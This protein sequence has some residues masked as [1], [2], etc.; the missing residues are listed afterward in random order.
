MKNIKRNSCLYNNKIIGIENF[1]YLSDSG[2][3]IKVDTGKIEEFRRLGSEDKLFCPCGCGARLCIV[4][5]EIQ[6]KHFRLKKNQLKIDE[7]CNWSEET[8]ESISSK[9]ILKIWLEQNNCIGLRRDILTSEIGHTDKKY[10]ITYYEPHRQIGVSY[11]RD[12]YNINEDKLNTISSILK[13]VFFITSIHNINNLW[14]YPEQ[15]IKIQKE[16][17]YTILLENNDNMNYLEAKLL[18]IY[19]YKDEYEEWTK[20]TIAYDYIQKYT[21]EDDE[22]IYNGKKIKAILSEKLKEIDE[23]LSKQKLEHEQLVKEKIR[24]AEIQYKKQAEKIEQE[25]IKEKKNIEEKILKQ[26][27]EIYDFINKNR[28]IK[29]AIDFLKSL[30]SVNGSFYSWQSDSGRKSFTR[31]F[32]INEVSF[33]YNL[34]KRHLIKKIIIHD[35]TGEKYFIYLKTNPEDSSQDCKTGA[36]YKEF[37]FSLN[38]DLDIV[39]A[40]KKDFV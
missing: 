16:Q 4:A 33:D 17:G 28:K 18:V 5:G 15:L 26:E 25:K 21:I 40:L 12:K 31:N 6:V 32:E 29:I 1:F 10:Q 39:N 14:Q 2:K 11:I 23:T 35:I 37:D 24:L 30:T 20:V 13:S 3:E 38:S 22:L 9:F 27:T 7:I 34:Y 36:F 8:E 19:Q